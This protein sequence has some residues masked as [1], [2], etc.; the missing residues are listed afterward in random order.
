M[1]EAH[2]HRIATAAPAHEVHDAFIRYAAM[3]LEDDRTRNLFHRMAEKS[4]IKSRH[5][6][7]S[8]STGP[9]G[10]NEVNAYDFFRLGAFP[11]T[12]QRMQIFEQAARPLL[13]C[14]LDRLAVTEDERQTVQHVIVTCCTG[15]YAPGM[16]F[17]IIDHLQ[18]PT[19]TDRTF[20][21]FMG[22]YAAVNGLKLARHIVR[23]QPGSRVLMVNLELCTLHL[24]QTQDL[25]KILSFLIF[26]DGC[27]ATLI[28]SEPQGL[29]MD[30]FSCVTAPESRDLITWRI[31]D[32]GFDMHLSGKVP[33]E[34]AAMLRSLRHQMPSAPD[35]EL[36]AIHPGGRTVLDAVESALSLPASALCASRRILRDFGNMSSA[37]VMFVLA[38]LL[39]RAR[40]GQRGYAMAFGPGLTA[41]TMRFHAV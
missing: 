30:G 33:G 15:F 8:V 34:I 10:P 11:S 39:Q 7:L 28:G 19:S 6:C 14:A 29:A 1:A 24:Q 9:A 37:T 32:G 26:A 22:C 16:D 41:E 18:L 36:W 4:A 5:S 17:D 38:A 35:T 12:E 13:R 2:V 23:S 21:G 25:G 31:G 40:A 20:L 27:A 3:M